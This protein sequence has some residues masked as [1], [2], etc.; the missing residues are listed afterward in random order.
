MIYLGEAD[1]GNG[2]LSLM[3]SKVLSKL[4]YFFVQCLGVWWGVYGDGV[5]F[6]DLTFFD[7]I[8]YAWDMTGSRGYSIDMYGISFHLHKY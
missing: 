1:V 6:F 3:H 4:H 7:I 8:M 2:A 5:V